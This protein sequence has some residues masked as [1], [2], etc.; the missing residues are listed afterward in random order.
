[1]R[2][3]FILLINLTSYLLYA[4]S[5]DSIRSEKRKEGLFVIHEVEENET[6]FS[7]ARRYGGNVQKIIVD[8]KLEGPGIDI[9]QIIEVFVGEKEQGSQITVLKKLPE[10]VHEVKSGE[11]LYSISRVYGV[12]VK[13]LKQWNDLSSNYLSPGVYLRVSKKAELPIESSESSDEK[14]ET[15]QMEDHSREETGDPEVTLT[16]SSYL[17]QTGETLA[18]IADKIGVSVEQLMDWN[19]LTSTFI[20]IGQELKYDITGSKAKSKG[21]AKTSLVDE[22]GFERTYEEGIAA[23]IS[24]IKT[25]KFLA[26]HRSL[27][28]GTELE[29]RNLMN[30]LVVHVKVVGKLPDTGINENVMLRLSPPAYD[31]LGIL[32]PKS[33]V[34][35]S[36]YK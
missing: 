30:N 25:S 27:P 20:K 15:V 7:I 5:L 24:D 13:Q 28:V 22:D 6:L 11:T 32:D 36:Y 18:S 9:G 10:D 14:V 31:Q 12:K 16:F 8:N 26:L 19:G 1:M 23:E 21:N 34:E 4:G 2:F 3:A 29:V 33:R 17:V 35:V